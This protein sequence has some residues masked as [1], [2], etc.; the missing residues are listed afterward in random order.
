MVRLVMKTEPDINVG[1]AAGDTSALVNHIKSLMTS[2]PVAVMD[3]IPKCIVMDDDQWFSYKKHLARIAKERSQAKKKPS[4]TVSRAKVRNQ[5][6]TTME[7]I[8]VAGTIVRFC[9]TKFCFTKF[10]S[11][12]SITTDPVERS[13]IY[14]AL[15]DGVS[16]DGYFWVV[17]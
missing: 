14:A 3:D 7:A 4:I 1:S 12:K 10:S 16:Y 11:V 2:H 6:D 8:E 5:R 9:E 15:R 13:N 17:I